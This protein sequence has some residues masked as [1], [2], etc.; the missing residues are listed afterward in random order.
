LFF[1]SALHPAASQAPANLA[2]VPGTLRLD[3]FYLGAYPLLENLPG[4]VT[5]TSAIAMLLIMGGIPWLP[6]FQKSAVA[7]VDLDNCNG[8][9]RCRED[10]PYNA[11]TMQV[12][13]DGKPFE[14]EAVVDPALCVACGI[15][16]GAC[17]TSTPFRRMSELSP[18]IDV[19][20]RKIVSIRDDTVAESARL[21][22]YPRI[23]IYGCKNAR[24]AEA[25]RSGLIG[26][27]SV[28]CSGQLPPAF[29][30]Y[31]LSR[32]LAEGVIIAGCAENSCFN[33]FGIKWTIERMARRRD[34]FLR[35]RVPRERLKLIWAGR[36][37][38]NFLDGSIAAF[39]TEL[40]KLEPDGQPRSGH[41]PCTRVG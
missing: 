21:S 33:R 18:G 16:A 36:V 14:G 39:A 1:L 12:R 25:H 9:T 17:P 7:V 22:G 20:G 5:W 31:V 3:W 37:G 4:A 32:K 2:E 6:P 41:G 23:M 35:S 11:I 34:P 15:C 10:C 8:C 13:S 19:S 26:V 27:V 29:I 40:Q 24:V 38:G 30:D 28:N